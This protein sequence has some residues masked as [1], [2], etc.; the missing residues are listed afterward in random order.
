VILASQT[1]AARAL[2]QRTH[3][4][5][6]VI[7]AS[8]DLV[9]TG[10]VK[11][12]ARPEGNITGFPS[13]EPT[14]AGKWLEILKEAAPSLVRIAIVYNPELIGSGDRSP[15]IS[16]IETTAATLGMQTV[17]IPFR[18]AI[19]LVRA[20]DNFAA[21]PN[22]GFIKLPPA[23][24]D[25]GTMFK[26]AVQHRLPAIYHLRSLVAA[27]GL[28]SY[29]AGDLRDGYPYQRVAS[30]VDRLLRG[31]KVSELPVQFPTKYELVINLKTAKAMGLTIPES[32]LLRAD[33]VIE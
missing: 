21:Q 18:D 30:Y 11:D 10:L 6:I 29:S 31:A 19:E 33:E 24:V 2:Q 32:F 9:A 22:C 1:V 5:P 12:T 4:I 23:T 13:N 14:L 28:I 8:G 25:D 26:L 17:A 20:I 15:F 7:T 27:G 16:S 3:T